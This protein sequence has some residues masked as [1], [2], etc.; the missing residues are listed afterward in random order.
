M[1]HKKVRIGAVSYLNTKPLVYGLAE[2]TPNATVTFDLPSRLADRL[3]KGDLDV[4]LIPSIEYFQNPNYTIVSDACIGCRGPVLSVKL[5]FRR[6]PGDVRTMAL[7]EGSRTSVVLARILLEH[8]FGVRPRFEGLPIGEGLAGTTADA[9]LLIGD[10]AMRP[11]EDSFVE[12]WD[13]GQQWCDW[14]ELPF[15]FAMWVAR[16]NEDVDRIEFALAS[17]RDLGEANLENIAAQEA[18]QAGMS[19]EECLGYLR[20]SLYFHFGQREQAGLTEFRRLAS[21]LGLAPAA[22]WPLHNHDR[23]TA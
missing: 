15:V 7:D 10:R 19:F 11:D 6:A 18:A 5:F 23:E 13:L 12:V 1:D 8:R 2:S 17:A 22:E 4:A 21:A 3:N 16:N 20:D 9:V 14:K